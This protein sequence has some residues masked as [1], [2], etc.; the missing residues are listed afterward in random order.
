M[1]KQSNEYQNILEDSNFIKT[2]DY[3]KYH[4]RV[5][6]DENLWK[7]N[8]YK[9]YCVKIYQSDIDFLMKNIYQDNCQENYVIAINDF[10]SLIC[11]FASDTILLQWFY[12]NFNQYIDVN[13]CNHFDYDYDDGGK[14]YNFLQLALMNKN[15]SLNVVRFLIEKCVIPY[16]DMI[17][18]DQ[19]MENY[20]CQFGAD[21]KIIKYLDKCSSRTL[22]SNKIFFNHMID[23]KIVK[24]AVEEKKLLV[25]WSDLS[26]LIFRFDKS[27]RNLSGTIK[28]IYVDNL[29]KIFGYMVDMLNIE[30][31]CIKFPCFF[32]P[33]LAKIC[34]NHVDNSQKK[35][36][37]LKI[38]LDSD[39]FNSKATERNKQMFLDSLDMLCTNP[40]K[41]KY[42][43]FIK[44]VH[45]CTGNHYHQVYYE[46]MRDKTIVYKSRNID[47]SNPCQNQLLFTHNHISY[48]GNRSIIY[49]QMLIFE[50]NPWINNNESDN[51]NCIDLCG[52]MDRYLVNIYLNCISTGQDIDLNQIDPDHIF[53]FLKF[54]E[55]Y[56]AKSL[57]IQT[58]ES[59]LIE[60]IDFHGIELN[61]ENKRMFERCEL[62]LL[63]LCVNHRDI[64]E[65]FR[66][67]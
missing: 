22:I 5:L 57:S 67:L 17:L 34:L 27:Y 2:W 65:S 45:D 16:D 33:K 44:H 20:D 38:M 12:N 62:K 21:F 55:Q 8:L 60:Y 25:S 30:D 43:D 59:Q 4:N 9:L 10:M 49:D 19:M 41:L 24:Y 26:N 53:E 29:G 61:D 13:H 54:I 56:P 36:Q 1:E 14:Y 64:F 31:N 46:Y 23:M 40:F 47:F 66:S 42:K 6:L 18:M 51:Q 37:I 15:K 32:S 39:A 58:V 28:K 3:L 52:Q 11:A 35:E 7:N 50:S 63:Y 48:Y